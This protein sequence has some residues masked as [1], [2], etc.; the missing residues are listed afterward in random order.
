[1]NRMAKLSRRTDVAKRQQ[2]L[3]GSND[4]VVNP[5]SGELISIHQDAIDKMNRGITMKKKKYE[6]T[7]TSKI[8]NGI[9]VYQIKALISFGNVVVDDLGGYVQSEKNLSHSGECW[10]YS[11]AIVCSNATVSQN[12]LVYGSAQIH[13]NAQISGSAKIYEY[14]IIYGHAKVYGMS[15]VYGEARVYHFTRVYDRAKIYGYAKIYENGEVF[16]NVEICRTTEVIKPLK[17]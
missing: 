12:A 14:A 15:E 9:K 8:V 16:N 2:E 1:M 7:N 10:V 3:S 11:N 4:L 5:W 6:L 13:D 17:N